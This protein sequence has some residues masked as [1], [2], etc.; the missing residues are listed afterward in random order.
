MG[1]CWFWKQGQ[2]DTYFA[3]T[4]EARWV[5]R[6]YRHGVR[7]SDEILYELEL[8]DHLVSRGIPAVA[9]VP[10]AAGR[11]W[12]DLDAPEGR[13]LLVVFPAAGGEG[14]SLENFPARNYG[15]LMGSLHHAAD[16]F[17]TGR[18]RSALDFDVLV[19]R[20]A[21]AAEPWLS[22]Q[23][24]E[25]LAAAV[26][27]L[28]DELGPARTRALDWGPCHNDVIGNVLHGP[29]D[30]WALFDFD[31]CGPRVAQPGVGHRRPSVRRLGQPSRGHVVRVRGR[32][33]A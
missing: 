3:E 10:T 28:R 32:L 8:M 5:A 11:R 27:V 26:E 20:P 22:R 16:S 13:R 2:N 33:P 23:D 30:E 21:E 1:W 24:A 7:D 9:S 14:P 25:T 29:E 31:S 19:T 4:G 12:A 6:L 18:V 17:V 15:R